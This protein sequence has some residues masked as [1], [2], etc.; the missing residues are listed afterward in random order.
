MVYGKKMIYKSLP[1]EPPYI[2]ALSAVGSV[3]TQLRL[4]K[5][6]QMTPL[7]MRPQFVELWII[8]RFL[9]RADPFVCHR[10]NKG[11]QFSTRYKQ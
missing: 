1:G 4:R 10:G 5:S 7:A 2:G 9:A 11:N 6:Y 8:H 3:S